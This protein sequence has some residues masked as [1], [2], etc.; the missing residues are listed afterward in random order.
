METEAGGT[1]TANVATAVK[2]ARATATMVL[3]LRDVGGRDLS[4]TA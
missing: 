2:T 1:V 4:M 3:E